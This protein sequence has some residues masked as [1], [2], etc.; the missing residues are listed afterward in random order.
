MYS[1]KEGPYINDRH[2]KVTIGFDTSY[3]YKNEYNKD[4]NGDFDY[5]GENAKKAQKFIKN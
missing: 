1:D 4:I 2:I 5:N 3:D